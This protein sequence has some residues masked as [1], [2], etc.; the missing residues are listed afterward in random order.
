[1]AN[2]FQLIKEDDRWTAKAS[3]EDSPT[4]SANYVE[5]NTN[6]PSSSVLSQGSKT[7]SSKPLETKK[8]QNTAIDVVNTFDWTTSPKSNQNFPVAPPSVRLEEHKIN[9]STF[10]QQMLYLISAGGTAVSETIN[11][12]GEV[13][14]ALGSPLIPKIARNTAGLTDTI[15][16]ATA[17]QA[18]NESYLQPY[19]GLYNTTKTPFLYNLPYFA[20]D[21]ELRPMILLIHTLDPAVGSALLPQQP[22]VHTS[23]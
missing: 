11:I 16:K 9:T 12:I 6:Y 18:S 3:G 10:I 7:V 17:F 8:S 2:L 23:M 15:A 5:K 21:G 1:M 20:N 13:E 14:K 19:D 4:N 22:L